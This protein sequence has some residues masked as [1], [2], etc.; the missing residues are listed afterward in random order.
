MDAER[1]CVKPR[2]LPHAAISQVTLQETKAL[3]LFPAVPPTPV[4]TGSWVS[5]LLPDG[6]VILHPVTCTSL[7]PEFFPAQ[8]MTG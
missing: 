3:P 7:P 5:C 2:S 4:E 8:N 1:F 6:T